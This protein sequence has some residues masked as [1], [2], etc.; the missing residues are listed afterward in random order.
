MMENNYD[1][2]VS[3][4]REDG[5]Q[6]ARILSLMLEKR[7]YKV[8]HD[9]TTLI[10]GNFADQIRN[11]IQDTHIFIMV[12]SP[13]YLDRCNN[14]IDWVRQEI[15][16]AYQFKKYIIPV[17]P[18]NLFTN[19]PSDIPTEIKQVV[20]M[21]QHAQV[22]F[23]QMLEASIDKLVESIPNNKKTSSDRN[24]FYDIFLAYPRRDSSAGDKLAEI[25][26]SNGFS[27]WRDVDG[28]Y[29]GDI[30]VD[31]IKNAITNSKV[32]IALNSKW[33]LK[34]VWFNKE[35]AFAQEKKKPIIKV[36]TDNPEG[37]S[38]TRRMSFGSILEM[39]SS[40]F[41]EKLLTGILNNGCKSNTKEMFAHGKGIYDRSQKSHNLED[42]F[43]AFSI[44]LRA[45]ELGNHD[46]Q[47]Y[48]ESQA[49]NID[50]RKAVLQYIPINNYFVLDLSAELYNRGEIIA[51]DETLTDNAQRGRGMEKAAFRMMKRAI[52]LGYEGNDPTAY[53]WY[54]LGE[55]DYEECLNML[56]SSSKMHYDKEVQPNDNDKTNVSLM[57]TSKKEELYINGSF[58]IFISYKRVDKKSVFSIKDVIEQKTGNRCWI[59]LDGIESDAQFA[60]VIIKA[61]SNAQVFLFMYSH[62]HSEIEDYDTDW[63]VRE[64]NFAQKKKKRIVFINIDGSPLTNWFEFMFGTKQHI[65]ASSEVLMDKLCKDLTKWLK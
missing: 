46:A 40:R 2:F 47:S 61:I 11:V 9:H 27:V 17:N 39:G 36:L 24:V 49:W 26:R 30:F 64:I 7:G 56:G 1:I 65:D 8:F 62:A 53:D 22:S 15:M 57:M 42:E 16:L 13:H 12:L 32:F 4:R 20:E 10:S 52:D 29:A 31:V 5:A 25:V 38:G 60:N 23:G 51:E 6:Y 55:K 28:I 59:D 14:E 44:L 35:L 19:V 63:T 18:D 45:A 3:Y 50:L 21:H 37:L 43:A 54:F 41:E 33:A 34:S 58:K 48:I